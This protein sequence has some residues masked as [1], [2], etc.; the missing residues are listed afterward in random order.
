M[1]NLGLNIPIIKTVTEI[2]KNYT[3]ADLPLAESLILIQ[4]DARGYSRYKN[5]K[6]PF[7]PR[8]DLSQTEELAGISVKGLDW[9]RFA[10]KNSNS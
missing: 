6:S 10:L 3:E 7:L 4:I 5:G 1:K 9:V 8:V 2:V